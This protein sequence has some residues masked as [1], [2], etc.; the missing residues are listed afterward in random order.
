MCEHGDLIRSKELYLLYSVVDVMVGDAFV[1]ACQNHH[2]ETARW[3]LSLKSLTHVWPMVPNLHLLK[4][5]H[6]NRE[7]WILACVSHVRDG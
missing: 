7:A 3:L 4:T 5:F 2:F 6:P 1:L